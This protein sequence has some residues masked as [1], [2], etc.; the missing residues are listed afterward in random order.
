MNDLV[1]E[2]ILYLMIWSS[3]YSIHDSAY[4]FL[5]KEC[6]VSHRMLGK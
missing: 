1:E 3:F 6:P 5:T 4:Q 2:S